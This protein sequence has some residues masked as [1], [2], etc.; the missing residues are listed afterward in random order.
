MK[1]ELCTLIFSA[2]DDNSPNMPEVRLFSKR[3][4]AMEA[5][6]KEFEEYL[7]KLGDKV[8]Y[9]DA[10]PHIT[11]DSA[12]ISACS[13]FD[14]YVWN[15]VPHVV[16]IDS[17][18]V[19]TPMG[20]LIVS[21]PGNEDYPGIS[22]DLLAKYDGESDII[23]L[24]NVEYGATEE[25]DHAGKFCIYVYPDMAKDEEP[26]SVEFDDHGCLEKAR[27]EK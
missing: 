16:E 18:K 20:T 25:G 12:Y 14:R 4:E 26:M 23:G 24:A 9:G 3:C 1:V 11:P 13:D 22:V 6:Q 8:D 10:V 17:V 2:N 7:L 15:I 27:K 5:M 21:D 19:D